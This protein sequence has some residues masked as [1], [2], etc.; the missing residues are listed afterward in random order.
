M[1]SLEHLISSSLISHGHP[2]NS[3]GNP[4]G[5][6]LIAPTDGSLDAVQTMLEVFRTELTPVFPFVVIPIGT[7]SDMFAREKPMLRMAIEVVTE[8]HG[9]EALSDL[10]RLFREEVSRRVIVNGEKSLDLLQSIL[11]YVAWYV[12]LLNYRSKECRGKH[13]P[14]R[15]RIAYMPFRNH[16]HVYPGS[17]FATMVHIATAL[18][19]DL[20][21]DEDTGSRTAGTQ[22]GAFRSLEQSLHTP[23]VERTLEEMRAILGL[24]WLS[25]TCV[26]ALLIFAL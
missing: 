19:S 11:V 23:K 16:L 17:H 6:S 18:A 2:A 15:R 12:E 5:P 24:F 14:E 13:Y 10:S 26:E 3:A 8:Q 4:A 25:S 22:L 9:K 7:T 20:G 1:E 21:L